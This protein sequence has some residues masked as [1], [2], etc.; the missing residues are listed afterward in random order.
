MG[1]A[2]ECVISAIDLDKK[3]SSGTI[4]TTSVYDFNEPEF[5]SWEYNKSNKI[6]DNEKVFRSLNNGTLYIAKKSIKPPTKYPE[7]I[8]TKKK[9]KIR[10]ITKFAVETSYSPQ[11]PYAS[12]LYQ[13]VL[14]KYCICDIG[15]DIN[16]EKWHIVTGKNK[17]TIT[18][19][20]NHGDIDIKFAFRA[21]D[22][23]KFEEMQNSMPRMPLLNKKSKKSLKSAVLFSAEVLGEF[24]KK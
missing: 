14:P 20:K 12:L 8:V 22:R 11:K 9:T 15:E 2:V 24:F 7:N 18:W 21:P 5:F 23:K 4:T 13:F 16:P 10:G 1:W 6:Q 19:L 3:H 17:Q